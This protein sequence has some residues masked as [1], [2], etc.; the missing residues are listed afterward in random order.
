M[1]I[2][3]RVFG[4]GDSARGF[5]WAAGV[6]AIVATIVLPLVFLV[7]REPEETGLDRSPERPV[8]YTHLD[9]YKRQCP[10][11]AGDQPYPERRRLVIPPASFRR[12]P[13]SQFFFC[14]GE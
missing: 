10:F 7:T 8:S 3:D 14:A 6:F 9:V 5:F 4:G 13:E 11:H 1:C 2:R 12:K